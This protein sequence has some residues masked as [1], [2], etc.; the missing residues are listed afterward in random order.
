[1]SLPTGKEAPGEVCCRRTAGSQ[2]KLVY[3]LIQTA[4]AAGPLGR[5]CKPFGE[6]TAGARRV[7]TAKMSDEGLE[8]HGPAAQRQI[9]QGAHGA[10]VDAVTGAAAPGALTS[11]RGQSRRNH[12]NHARLI[13]ALYDKP[14]RNQSRRIK[15]L[16]HVADSLADQESR[17]AN[18]SKIEEA[19]FPRRRKD[20]TI[21]T[22]DQTPSSRRDE[23][24]DRLIFIGGGRPSIRQ[25]S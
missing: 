3:D 16:R 17:R 23:G 9:A 6:N 19:I 15:P 5:C 22:W 12:H 10:A 18:F 11:Y 8:L 21:K 13:D 4:R 14:G 1:M 2:S 7:I 20:C 25:K 24:L